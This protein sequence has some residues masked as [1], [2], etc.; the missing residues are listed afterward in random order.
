VKRHIDD[1]RPEETASSRKHLLPQPKNMTLI[2]TVQYCYVKIKTLLYLK[3]KS[4]DD[5]NINVFK[6]KL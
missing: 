6:Y 1:G 5:K 2:C 3:S 4:K